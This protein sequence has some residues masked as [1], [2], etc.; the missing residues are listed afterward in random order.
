MF[1]FKTFKI[2]AIHYMP[3]QTIAMLMLLKSLN[4]ASNLVPVKLPWMFFETYLWCKHSFWRTK[5]FF[6]SFWLYE[7]AFP[8]LNAVAWII[9]IWF[10]LLVKKDVHY[11]RGERERAK[12]CMSHDIVLFVIDRII[13]QQVVQLTWHM[14]WF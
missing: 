1:D 9:S 3:P 14:V 8:A 11:Y 4:V 5:I 10:N 12:I 6:I 2:M 13:W 7:I